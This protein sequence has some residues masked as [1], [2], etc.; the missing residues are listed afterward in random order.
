MLIVNI[1]LLV[2]FLLA[3]IVNQGKLVS[4]EIIFNLLSKR[5]E[6]GEAKG[7]SGFIL[8][9]FP[10]TIRQAETLNEVTEID[11]SQPVEGS[12]RDQGKLMEFYLPGGI[13]ESWPKLLEALNLDDYEVKRTAVA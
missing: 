11:L 2:Q 1:A 8:D 7:E 4:D 5:L 3:E 12:Y 9:G 13:P 6:A 10:R